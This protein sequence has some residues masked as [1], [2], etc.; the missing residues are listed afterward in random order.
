MTDGRLQRHHHQKLTLFIVLVKITPLVKE[1][2]C[3]IETGA[4]ET[5]ASPTYYKK[6]VATA[7]ER[8][9]AIVAEATKVT[10]LQPR[11]DR[12]AATALH[13]QKLTARE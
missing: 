2:P 5:V 9:V 4:L 10:A 7:K 1:S 11:I 3:I 13:H 8:A 6:S 12:G